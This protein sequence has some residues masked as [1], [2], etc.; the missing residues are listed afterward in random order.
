M[1]K[2][3]FHALIVAGLFATAAHAETLAV[4]GGIALKPSSVERPARG[5]SM[6]TVESRFGAP[7]SKHAAVGAPPISRWDYNG[8][9]VFFEREL[10]IHAVAT[11]S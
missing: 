3:P 9:S 1:S 10:V 8:F 6:S 11:G 5:L 4:D 2:L 7:A